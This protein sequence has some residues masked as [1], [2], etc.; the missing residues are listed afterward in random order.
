LGYYTIKST[1]PC[2][3]VGE[4][5]D[6]ITIDLNKVSDPNIADPEIMK[7][8]FNDI[9]TYVKGVIQAKLGQPL[10]E[11]TISMHVHH[12]TSR[13]NCDECF[14]LAMDEISNE[15]NNN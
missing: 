14:R 3:K 10:L 12:S 15:Q 7:E 8:I 9:S 11:P 5:P 2:W 4:M 6:R 1:Q 13:S